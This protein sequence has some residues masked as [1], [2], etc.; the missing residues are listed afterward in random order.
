MKT[1]SVEKTPEEIERE[2]QHATL[3][4]SIDQ[5]TNQ[6]TQIASAKKR[7]SEEKLSIESDVENLK[8]QKETYESEIQLLAIQKADE[9]KNVADLKDEYS[10][11][12]DQ[13]EKALPN[14]DEYVSVFE[15][16]KLEMSSELNVI[17]QKRKV[18]EKELADIEVKKQDVEK[19]ISLITTQYQE[20]QEQMKGLDTEIE[21][22]NILIGNLR[23]A[24]SDAQQSI[25]EYEGKKNELIIIKKDII[26]AGVELQDIKNQSDQAKKELRDTNDEHTK[27]HEEMNE[28]IKN[29]S[30]LERRIDDKVEIFKQY[31][32][33][34]T[35]D[36]LA[37]MKINTDIA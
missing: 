33:K 35:V 20:K 31:K 26:E 34:F 19:Y 17:E 37:R 7:V 22:K 11:K 23:T 27:K 9:L 36:E 3:L 30:A 32:E 13:L 18:A 1:T 28:K 5:S 6:L 21:S 24:V 14:V 8:Q 2:T 12:K 25:A 4:V 16:R 10:A 29:L 15:K